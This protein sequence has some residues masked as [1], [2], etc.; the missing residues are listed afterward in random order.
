MN[1]TAIVTGGGRGIGYAIALMLAE[2]GYNIVVNYNSSQEAAEKLSEK[3][4]KLGCKALAVKAN[5]GNFD[6]SFKLI[7]KAHS[8]FGRVDLLVN[9]AGITRDSLL[10]RMNEKDF[11]SVIEINLK[12]TFN[13][14]KHV[15]PIMIKQRFGKIIN[16][17]SVIGLAGNIGQINYA[18][19]KAG[20][21]GITKSAAKE[22]AS[23]GITVNAIAPGYIETDM[24]NLLPTKI[25]DSILESIPLKKFGTPEDVAGLVCFLASEWADYI[26]G[27]VIQV[28]GGMLM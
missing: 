6:E 4:E 21:I 8:T 16:I 9:N 25:K 28:D 5:V 2:N 23:R 26:T 15:S 19:A 10:L 12:G 17:S 14:I 1:K 20:I 24:T 13:C 7:N 3:I 22:L 11:D 27:Q 18:A